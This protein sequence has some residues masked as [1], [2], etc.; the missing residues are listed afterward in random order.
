MFA[1]LCIC[2]NLLSCCEFRQLV[3]LFIFPSYILF[4]LSHA[5]ERFN[6]H[7]FFL[8]VQVYSCGVLY[9]FFLFFF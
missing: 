1:G 4:V 6:V 9:C 5:F 2:C 8:G 7:M 3:C